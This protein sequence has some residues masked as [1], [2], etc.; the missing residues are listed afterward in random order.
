LCLLALYRD[1]EPGKVVSQLLKPSA[2][3]GQRST[4]RA[5][6]VVF[7]MFTF[8]ICVAAAL[9]DTFRSSKRQAVLSCADMKIKFSH[10]VRWCTSPYIMTGF[11]FTP[12]CSLH[13]R[14]TRLILRVVN[15]S[16]TKNNYNNLFASIT[17][18]QGSRFQSHILRTSRLCICIHLLV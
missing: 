14:T 7:P 2:A 12:E 4:C 6:R 1:I 15:L 17:G 3:V 16:R 5:C 11:V 9:L 10:D 18:L 8:S 13:L